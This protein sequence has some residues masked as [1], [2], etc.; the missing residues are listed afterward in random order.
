MMSKTLL[1]GLACL[2]VLASCTGSYGKTSPDLWLSRDYD[3]QVVS[4]GWY[5]FR[6]TCYG[7]SGDYEYSYYNIPSGWRDDDKGDNKYRNYLYYPKGGRNGRYQVQVKVYDIQYSVQLTQYLV[8]EINGDSLNIFVRETYDYSYR[9]VGQYVFEKKDIIEF[10]SWNEVVSLIEDGDVEGL[11]DIIDRVIESDNDCDDKKDFLNGVLNRI[12]KYINTSSN[13]LSEQQ[14]VLDSLQAKLEKYQ[15]ILK[16][17]LEER[18]GGNSDIS[19]LKK[20]LN[21]AYSKVRWYQKRI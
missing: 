7:G 15:R 6:P 8:I 14:D 21:D 9:S 3:R 18:K 11:S 19:A 10:P 2:A 4:G 17:L 5:A 13:R 12:T 16:D 20:E 1:L